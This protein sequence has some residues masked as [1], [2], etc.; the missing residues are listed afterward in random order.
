MSNSV[1]LKQPPRTLME[2]IMKAQRAS[3]ASRDIKIEE[4]SLD[5]S[6][7]KPIKFEMRE[8]LQLSLQ[9]S[10]KTNKSEKP[11]TMNELFYKSHMSGFGGIK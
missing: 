2:K 8:K 11:P 4:D 9:K 7:M 6:S 5:N 10:N 1:P 3:N